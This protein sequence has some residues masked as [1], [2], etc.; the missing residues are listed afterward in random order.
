MK[1]NDREIVAKELVAEDLKGV[2][3]LIYPFVDAFDEVLT[4][5]NKIKSSSLFKLIGENTDEFIT[6]CSVMTGLERDWVAK[7]P[8]T[9]LLSLGKE[10]IQVNHDFFLTVMD[11]VISLMGELNKVS[12]QKMKNYIIEAGLSI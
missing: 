6:F 2:C 10:V 7:L 4:K 1:I 8:P 11:G 9:D 12:N 3:M 5:D